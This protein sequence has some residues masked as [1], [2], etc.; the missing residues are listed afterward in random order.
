LSTFTDPHTIPYQSTSTNLDA[1]GNVDISTNDTFAKITI[2]AYTY[3]IKDAGR[4]DC[5]VWA[6]GA[7]GS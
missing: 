4:S 7:V 5:G 2:G 6:D 3:F 1:I